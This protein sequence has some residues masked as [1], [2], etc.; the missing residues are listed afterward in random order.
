MNKIQQNLLLSS[1]V[2]S[3][4][5]DYWRRKLAGDLPEIKLPPADLGDATAFK[6]GARYLNIGIEA[7]LSG[8]LWKFS[9]GS[10]MSLYLILL[11]GLKC[12]LYRYAGNEDVIVGSPLY[13][14]NCTERTIN[15]FVAIRDHLTAAMTFKECLLNV[16]RS[17]IEAYENQDYPFE[18]I[19]RQ[20]NP[21]PS[22]VE[23]SVFGIFCSLK[24]IHRADLIRDFK[25]KVTFSFEREGEI[26]KGRL[27]FSTPGF[28]EDVLEYFAGHFS[29]LLHQVLADT[30]LKLAD[31]QLLSSA[32][33]RRIVFDFNATTVEY[34]KETTIQELFEDQVERTPGRVAVVDQERRLTYRELNEKANRLAGVLRDKGVKR[35]SFVA[36]MVERSWEM[37]VGIMGI[38]KAGGAYLPID[39]QYPESRIKYMLKDS[40]TNILLARKRLIDIWAPEVQDTFDLE[41]EAALDGDGV[42]P[43]HNG[44]SSDLAYLIYTSGTTGRPKGVMVE[45]RGIANLKIF[46]AKQFGITAADNILQFAAL[47]FDA[48]AWEIFMGLLAGAALHIASTDLIGNSVRFEEYLNQNNITVATL[49]P[50]I[51]PR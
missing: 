45:H 10:D 16:R 17:A 2:F 51:P 19:I 27:E 18:R 22:Q 3:K 32:E 34:P 37:I 49:P 43:P 8:R 50:L 24:N 48:S 46:F 4:Q 35:D 23:H 36:I 7:D 44:K 6:A 11:T 41:Q 13:A 14:P 26:L 9:K 33:I 30:E 40:G 1:E 39:P 47:T 38:L 42:N 28:R 15:E 21:M 12:L 20:L 25:H 31:I 29:G 5:N